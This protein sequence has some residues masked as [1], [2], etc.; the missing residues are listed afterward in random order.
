MGLQRQVPPHLAVP[1]INLR[2][3]HFPIQKQGDE[4]GWAME[5]DLVLNLPLCKE[6]YLVGRGVYFPV[7]K[8]GLM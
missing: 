6:S 4:R 8:V 2:G 7:Y 5:L 1:Y 3:V